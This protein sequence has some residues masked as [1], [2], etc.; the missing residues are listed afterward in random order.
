MYL[1]WNSNCFSHPTSEKLFPST[2]LSKWP[3]GEVLVTWAAMT[4]CLSTMSLHLGHWQSL[5]LQKRLCPF[6]GDTKPWFLQRE[7]LGI[8]GGFGP[9]DG[10]TVPV[11]SPLLC[12]SLLIATGFERI[13]FM[14][15]RVS[16]QPVRFREETAEG[17]PP[18]PP[19]YRLEAGS[20]GGWKRRRKLAHNWHP[21]AAPT[22]Y[23]SKIQ[24]LLYFSCKSHIIWNKHRK[25]KPHCIK[26]KQQTNN[27]PVYAKYSNINNNS[28]PVKFIWL[29]RCTLLTGN[30]IWFIK[31]N[32]K[33][34]II[35][36]ISGILNT[37]VAPL[38]TTAAQACRDEADFTYSN[39]NKMTV[40]H[41][42]RLIG[43]EWGALST[44]DLIKPLMWG[45]L[46][47]I[48]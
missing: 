12:F 35:S 47:V 17:H 42:S 4:L 38:H 23:Q 7:H 19:C 5:Q 21:S 27:T 30:Y 43:W 34:C 26:F 13:W 11:D 31:K 22:L 16:V 24:I 9:F 45:E 18:I 20:G 1:F 40:A 32:K 3:T 15:L 46:K 6:R 48:N 41:L 33:T 8:L 44:G 28:I 14:A 39:L 2:I 29:P 36:N 25:T 37:M 10:V